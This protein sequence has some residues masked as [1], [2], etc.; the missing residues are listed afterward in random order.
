MVAETV[1]QGANEAKR[2]TSYTCLTNSHAFVYGALHNFCTQAASFGKAFLD[3]YD[4]SSFVDMARTL[5][6]LNAVRHY[7]IGIPITYDE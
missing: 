4:P 3:L 1:A 5:R 6:V 2:S 7:E